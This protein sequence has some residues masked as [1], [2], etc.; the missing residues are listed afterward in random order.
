[1]KVTL[2]GSGNLAT[3]LG[4]AL[5]NAG[6]GIF[7]IYSRTATHA[8]RLADALG[9]DSFCEQISEINTLSDIYIVAV[10]DD[11]L[12]SVAAE[13]QARLPN[14]LI[15]HTAGSMPMDVISNERRGVFYPMQTFSQQRIVPFTHIPIFIEASNEVDAQMLHNLADTL[16]DSVYELSSDD[17]KWL[18][19]AAVFCCNFTNHMATLSAR[20]LESH[21]IPFRVLLPLMEETV[22]KLRQMPPDEAQTGPAVRGDKVVMQNHLQA[23]KEHPEMAQIYE[24]ISNSIHHD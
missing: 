3:N 4:H 2:L 8:Q 12:P 7:Q 19:I 10:K 5:K 22:A 16:S 21:G 23:L 18:H 17:R 15:V 20:L 1:M 14:R 13:L 24:L 11:A 6:V 9:V